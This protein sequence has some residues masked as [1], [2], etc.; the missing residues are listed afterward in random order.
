MYIHQG[1]IMQ[2]TIQKWGNSLGVR[3]PKHLTDAKSFKEGSRVVLAES[4]TGITIEV[5]VPKKKLRLSDMVKNMNAKNAH[6]SV[7]WGEA[8][9]NEAW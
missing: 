8:V 7:D 5:A 2:L 4:A 9:G 6:A 3:L 1:S